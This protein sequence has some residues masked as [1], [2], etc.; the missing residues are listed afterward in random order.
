MTSRDRRGERRPRGLVAGRPHSA[1]HNFPVIAESITHEGHNP[2]YKKP[3][4]NNQPHAS[5]HVFLRTD[6]AAGN[7]AGG[8]ERGNTRAS[9]GSKHRA[10]GSAQRASGQQHVTTPT[11]AHQHALMSPPGEGAPGGGGGGGDRRAEV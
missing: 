7:R 4:K 3:A 11:H 2:L 1:D 9:R 8:R 10:Q 5:F 6:I